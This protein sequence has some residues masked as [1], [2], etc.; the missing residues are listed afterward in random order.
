LDSV[1]QLTEKVLSQYKGQ[2][3]IGDIKEPWTSAL[4]DRLKSK[5]IHFTGVLGRH[6]EET[7]AFE[8]SAVC[9]QKGLELDDLCEEFYQRL[10][11]CQ[12]KLGRNAEAAT[13]YQRCSNRLST[14][15]GITPSLITENINQ[16]IRRA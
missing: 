6:W 10:M 1:V 8:R 5:F 7:G 11:I 9:F 14:A 16:S 13:T 12:L 3:L 15:L 4:R 2:F